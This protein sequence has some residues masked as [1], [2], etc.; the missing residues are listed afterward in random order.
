MEVMTDRPV[1]LICR[2]ATMSRNWPPCF[3]ANLLIPQP[4]RSGRALTWAATLCIPRALHSY[5]QA[6]L[7]V[8]PTTPNWVPTRGVFG[9]QRKSKMFCF[10]PNDNDEDI[11]E[12]T[13]YTEAISFLYQ[14]LTGLFLHLQGIVHVTRVEHG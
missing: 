6:T 8:S 3:A 1:R 13:L 12:P 11:F 14:V 10:C 7:P 4:L 5:L 2:G 9:G